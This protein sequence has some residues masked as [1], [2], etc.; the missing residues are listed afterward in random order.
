MDR[1]AWQY[2]QYRGMG[3]CDFDSIRIVDRSS[4]SIRS[5]ECW[6]IR[7]AVVSESNRVEFC[8]AWIA[9][10]LRK[11]SR[12]SER[13]WR[14]RLRDKHASGQPVCVLE[15]VPSSIST[16]ATQSTAST[17]NLTLRTPAGNVFTL[18]AFNTTT[19]I[20]YLR[21]Y[22]TSSAPT[23]SSATGFV[24]TLPVPPAAGSGGAGGF[25]RAQQQGQSYSTGISFCI[26]GGGTSTD[27]TNA[28]AG[29]YV[30]VLYN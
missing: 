17:Y 20:Y 7:R 4:S 29:L 5:V 26:T 3:T 2:H 14:E 15:I 6:T 16:S 24:E 8:R 19:T 9:E 21:M 13:V 18:S 1:P 11:F 12:R 23:C 22:N 30:T 28:A 25:V 10:R 27:N